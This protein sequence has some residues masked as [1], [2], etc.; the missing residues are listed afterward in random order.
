M[1][2]TDVIKTG[3]L[4]VER[5]T[6]HNDTAPMA[7]ICVCCDGEDDGS[8]AEEIAFRT[9]QTF[10]KVSC[11]LSPEI[12]YPTLFMDLVKVWKSLM[13]D[14]VDYRKSTMVG[15]KTGASLILSLSQWCRDHGIPLPSSLVLDSPYLGN[16]SYDSRM[17]TYLSSADSDDPYAYPLLG[18]YFLFPPVCLFDE[19]DSLVPLKNKLKEERIKYEYSKNS[20]REEYI[21]SAAG[22]ISENMY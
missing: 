3:C 22:F 2:N 11:C 8:A 13:R 14:G 21:S 17:K 19:D 6:L 15:K 10:Y 4:E 9:A 18:D 20:T 1:D 5:I 7:L 12:M 16:D